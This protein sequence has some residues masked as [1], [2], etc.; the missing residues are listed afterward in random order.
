MLRPMA[1]PHPFQRPMRTSAVNRPC[2]T[3]WKQGTD[4]PPHTGA[5]KDMIP[6]SNKTPERTHNMHVAIM[7]ACAVQHPA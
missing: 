4:G 7:H 6:V 1:I 2:G 5:L 3:A